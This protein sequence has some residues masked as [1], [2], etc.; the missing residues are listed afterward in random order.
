MK[1]VPKGVDHRIFVQRLFDVCFRIHNV[2]M[3]EQDLHL[4][5]EELRNAAIIQVDSDNL[6]ALKENWDS[7]LLLCSLYCLFCLFEAQPAQGRVV[8]RVD[9]HHFDVFKSTFLSL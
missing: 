5:V 9:D 1:A 3:E 6:K 8:I 2:S 4:L 7:W